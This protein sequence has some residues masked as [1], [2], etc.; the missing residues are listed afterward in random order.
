MIEMEDSIIS[1]EV[2]SDD[3]T[4]RDELC[5]GVM[6][7]QIKAIRGNLNQTGAVEIPIYKTKSNG[8]QKCTV[9]FSRATGR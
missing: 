7:K 9:D 6:E 1:K 2:E 8:N 4:N 5:L 3:H